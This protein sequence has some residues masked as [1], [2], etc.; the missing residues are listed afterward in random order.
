MPPAAPRILHPVVPGRLFSLITHR[1]ATRSRPGVTAPAVTGRAGRWLAAAAGPALLPVPAQPAAATLT[2]AMR[3]VRHAATAGAR[4]CR[5][6]R[7]S[8]RGR[9]RI[10][11]LPA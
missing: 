9:R 10:G 4:G 5:G 8:L 2:V 11:M 7:P 3:L 1:P 6:Q